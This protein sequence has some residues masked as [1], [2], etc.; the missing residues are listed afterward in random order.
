VNLR[1]R[2]VVIGRGGRE[3]ALAWRLARD[4]EVD[5]VT[6]APGNRSAATRFRSLPV[7]ETDS[8]A[9]TRVCRDAGATLA[10]IGPEASLAAGAVD[11]LT[12]A[13]IP[14][15]GPTRAA[16]RIESSKWF[17]KEIMNE[18]N[19]PTARATRCAT[20]A[21]ALAAL[22]DYSAPWVIKADGLAAGKGVL[23]S[24]DRGPVETFIRSCLEGQK[25]GEQGAVIVIEEYLS[26]EEVSVMAVCDG[27]R[28]ALL[29]S[30]RDH[31]R[32]RDG[33]QGPNTGGMGAFA[34]SPRLDAAGAADLSRRVIAPV[35]A[36][37]AARGTPFRG[38]LYAGLMLTAD[39]PR[40][41]EFNARF[42]DPETQVVMPLVEGSLAR[43]LD[44]A[45]RG[46]LDAGAIRVAPGATV[47]VTLVDEGYPE[48]VQGT[49]VIEGLDRIEDDDTFA[50]HAGTAPAGARWN[51]TGGRAVTLVA[52]R[53]TRTAARAAAYQAIDTLGGRGWRC[54]RDI[55]ADCALP[56]AGGRA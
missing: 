3:H 47:G 31:K 55:A 42:G 4:P 16:A 30:A 49:G 44:G 56:V 19:V 26:G 48:R 52:R 2:I 37:L 34:P 10:V 38:T 32:A 36:R 17:A 18:A 1:H 29:P 13:G 53:A 5:S 54:R 14:A 45:A 35:L 51:V 20:V 15:Y 8:A 24:S 27:E 28:H 22:A 9:V 25:F 11:A 33:D 7:D 6:L 39:G 43:L 41:L 50:F 21:A 46:A 12:E 40:V 23:V